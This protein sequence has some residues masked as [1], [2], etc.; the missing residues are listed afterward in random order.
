MLKAYISLFLQPSLMIRFES[1]MK[2]EDPIGSITVST[3]KDNLPAL[4]A[5]I[6]VSQLNEKN[7]EAH[8]NIH[9]DSG[10]V[11]GVLIIEGK[12]EFVILQCCC[13]SLRKDL[14]LFLLG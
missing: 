7:I 5:E 4:T 12:I 9:G 6:L 8:C 1:M 10:P 11:V 13:D 14:S 3:F 2:K